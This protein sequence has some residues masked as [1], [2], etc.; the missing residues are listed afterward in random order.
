VPV[1]DAEERLAGFVSRE[2]ITQAL[3]RQLPG[4]EETDFSAMGNRF[5]L[6]L[7]TACGMLRAIEVG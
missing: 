2:E 7:C 5:R 1:M 3:A 6:D 4:A